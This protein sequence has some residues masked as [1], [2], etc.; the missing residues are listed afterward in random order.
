VSNPPWLVGFHLF[1]SYRSAQFLFWEIVFFFLLFSRSPQEEAA[2]GKKEKNLEK[3]FSSFSIIIMMTLVQQTNKQTTAITNYR[4]RE[5]LYRCVCIQ[6]LI[7]C[8]HDI[9]V[10]CLF[11]PV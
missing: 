11:C 4:E 7:D 5:M 8:T 10:S 2:N 1:A 6:A 3:S 9:C